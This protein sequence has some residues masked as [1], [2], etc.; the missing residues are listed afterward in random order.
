MRAADRLADR[1]GDCAR[2]WAMRAGRVDH[3]IPR[4]RKGSYFPSFLEPRC[5]GVVGILPDAATLIGLA[6]IPM[7]ER[8]DAGAE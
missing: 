8:P 4:L 6:S 2:G 3:V 7:L 5:S 1:N